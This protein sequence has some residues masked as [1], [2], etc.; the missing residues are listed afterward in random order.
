VS[1]P[2]HRP[3]KGPVVTPVVTAFHAQKYRTYD[4][5]RFLR[6]N[7]RWSYSQNAPGHGEEKGHDGPESTSLP[8]R[9]GAQ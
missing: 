6:P 3:P 2:E 1:H 7:N 5:A 8:Q 4:Q 9:R